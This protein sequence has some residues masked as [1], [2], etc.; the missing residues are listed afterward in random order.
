MHHQHSELK[1]QIVRNLIY[2]L[3][4]LTVAVSDQILKAMAEKHPER[5]G[6][7]VHNRGFAGEKLSSRP[8]IVRKTS[9]IV[10]TFGF[11]LLPF[12]RDDSLTGRIKKAGWGMTTGAALSNT[13]DRI[14]RQRVTDYIPKG[15]YVYNLSDFAISSG[16]FLFFAGELLE[17]FTQKE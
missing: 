9:F 5:F 10:N 12:I 6:T 7:V 4:G 3:P 11:L 17:Y 2:L 13:L 15:K 8:D 14:I 1:N 16:M